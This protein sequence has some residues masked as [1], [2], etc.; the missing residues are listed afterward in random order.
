MQYFLYL[1]MVIYTRYYMYIDIVPE[2]VDIVHKNL[3]TKMKKR[4][5]YYPKS[6]TRITPN[7]LTQ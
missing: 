1:K 6:T 5:R 7:L 2:Y 4:D 3:Y